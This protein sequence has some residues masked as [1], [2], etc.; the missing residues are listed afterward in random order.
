M[1]DLFASEY[2]WGKDEILQK[3]YLDEVFQLQE[4]IKERKEQLLKE[5]LS[6]FRMQ[7]SIYHAK[8]P[9]EIAKVLE[10]ELRETELPGETLDVTGME[11]LKG[12]MVISRQFDI[13]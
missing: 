6:D 1:V 10:E 12:A 3:V 9:Q 4:A 11:K 7:L 8:D 13:K 2:G 5:K